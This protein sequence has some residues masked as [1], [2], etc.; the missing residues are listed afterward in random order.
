LN[1]AWPVPIPAGSLG[2]M[3]ITLLL[4]ALLLA[5]AST[6]SYVRSGP[7]GAVRA[8][9]SVAGAGVA[10][11]HRWGW[12]LAGS[13]AVVRPFDPPPEP[14][15]P[16]HRGVDLA[17]SPDAQVLAAG[18]GMV[19]FAGRVAGR[20]VVSVDHRGGLRTTYEWVTA[21]VHA[22]DEV[23]LGSPLGALEAGHPHCAAAACLHWGLR[24]GTVYLDPL[25]LLKPLRVRLKPL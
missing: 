6:A 21:V 16:G 19:A 7:A 25:L 3:L 13:P 14:W 23:A 18:S 8:T 9:A 11:A 12:P 15:L 10:P 4:L 20:G 22:G 1:L 17:A 24:R 2:R 5:P